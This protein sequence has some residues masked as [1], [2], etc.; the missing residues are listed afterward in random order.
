MANNIETRARGGGRAVK[1]SLEWKSILS[2]G[3]WGEAL[4]PV[5]GPDMDSLLLEVSRNTKL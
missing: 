2:G 4:E 3:R 5:P 1:C